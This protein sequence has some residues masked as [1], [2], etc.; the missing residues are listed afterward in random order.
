MGNFAS[1]N[2]KHYADLSSCSDLPLVWQLRHH[3]GIPVLVPQNLGCLLSLVVVELHFSVG[4]MSSL[5]F[6]TS[7]QLPQHKGK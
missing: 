3:A 7:I 2:Q 5:L 1:T 6:Q 4:L